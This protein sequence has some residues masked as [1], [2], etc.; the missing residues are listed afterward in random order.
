M[1]RFLLGLLLIIIGLVGASVM[2]D[3][4]H[5]QPGAVI[6]LVVAFVGL[7]MWFS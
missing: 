4:F 6:G 2:Y 5:S 1:K 7:L 3:R